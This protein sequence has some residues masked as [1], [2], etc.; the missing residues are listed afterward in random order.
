M[1]VMLIIENRKMKKHLLLSVCSEK[2]ANDIA[3]HNDIEEN[4]LETVLL[5]INDL[6]LSPK[7]YKRWMNLEKC[8]V[9][10]LVTI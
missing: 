6:I 7:N 2:L 9:S 8:Y 5:E 4:V 10:Y 3:I 1:I